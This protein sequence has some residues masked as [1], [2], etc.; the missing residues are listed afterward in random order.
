[1]VLPW[2]VL[3][4]SL[5]SRGSGMVEYKAS[6]AVMLVL[7]SLLVAGKIIYFNSVTPELAQYSS[8]HAGS[9]L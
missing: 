4:L 2:S 5:L 9:R 1:L 7:Q 6:C 8:P 3:L